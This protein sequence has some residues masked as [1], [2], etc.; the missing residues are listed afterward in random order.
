MATTDYIAP[1]TRKDVL[2]RLDSLGS[3]ATVLAGGQDVA[4]LMN[5][6]RFAPKAIVDLKRVKGLSGIVQRNGSIAVGARTTHR[7]IE[8]SGL[9][10]EVNGLLVDAA[11]AAS[12]RWA[13]RLGFLLE[14]VGAGA[15]CGALKG[16]VRRHA[17]NYTRLLPSAPAE[18]AVR[19]VDWRLFVNAPVEAGA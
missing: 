2:A 15:T 13:Q 17:R 5:Q 8:R 10:L 4:P 12:V 1:A 18:G 14:C 19:S 6:G 16:Y 3:R 9:L 11:G 7:E